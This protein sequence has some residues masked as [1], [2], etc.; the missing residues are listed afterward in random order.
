M[1][2]GVIY[3]LPIFGIIVF[4]LLF[5]YSTTVYPGGSQANMSSPGFNWIHNYWCNLTDKIAMNG[6]NN[7]ARPFAITAMILLCGSLLIFFNLFAVNY[8]GSGLRKKVIQTSGLL[9]M[10]FTSMIFTSWH[11]QMILLACGAGSIITIAIIITGW[12]GNPLI[13]KITAGLCTVLLI[14]NALIYYT[15]QYLIILPLLQKITFLLILLWITGLNFRMIQINN[16]K[17]T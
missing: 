9:S 14:L 7:P 2:K 13:Y 10:I 12:K 3:Y 5:Y 8:A 17:K 4:L 6:S 1:K 15:G 11:N 16:L